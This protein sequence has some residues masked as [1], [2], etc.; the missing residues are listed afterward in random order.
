MIDVTASRI[1]KSAEAMPAEIR[2]KTH[3]V[4]HGTSQIST[5]WR[6]EKARISIQNQ[7]YILSC[8]LITITSAIV[9]TLANIGRARSSVPMIKKDK[10]GQRRDQKAPYAPP[11]K[12]QFLRRS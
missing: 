9:A 2:G 12:S 5:I 10:E 3:L 4:G 6:A 1:Q 11:R 7:A 8:R